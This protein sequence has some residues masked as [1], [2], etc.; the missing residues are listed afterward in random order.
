MWQ[1]IAWSPQAYGEIKSNLEVARAVLGGLR[2]SVS[3]ESLDT[4]DA[5]FIE[6]AQE[7]WS[8]DP[9]SRP[10]FDEVLLRLR[11]LGGGPARLLT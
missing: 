3:L 2:P 5:A 11:G 10:S 6:L 1:L 4:P 9:A 7:C 8:A